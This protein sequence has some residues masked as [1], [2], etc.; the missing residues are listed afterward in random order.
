V[1]Y[2]EAESGFC[3]RCG[4]ELAATDPA[5]VCAQCAVEVADGR[6]SSV[7]EAAEASG[8]GRRSFDAAW[9]RR[10]GS[11]ILTG[12]L[13][14]VLLFRLPVLVG[15]LAPAPAVH[16]GTIVTDA[17]GNRCVSNLWSVAHSLSEREPIDPSLE[18]P[19]S[20]RPYVKTTEA[21]VTVVSCPD[22]ALHGAASLSVRSDALVPAVR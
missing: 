15:A 7:R 20:D 10:W 18:C 21:G 11:P 6:L 2:D 12:I 4:R 19:A 13:T 8:A 1:K 16:D 14:L 9:L 3:G 17:T 5:P 22:P